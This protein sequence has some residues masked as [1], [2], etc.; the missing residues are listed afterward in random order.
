MRHPI[1]AESHDRLALT[2]KAIGAGLWDYDID[3]D[4]LQCSRRWYDILGLDPVEQPV[5][6]IEDFK[7][8]IHPD[9]VEIATAVD[10][11]AIERLLLTD[12]PYHVEFRIIRPDGQIRRLRSVASVVADEDNGHRRAVGCV[13]DVTDD[14][15]LTSAL[16]LPST[17]TEA[18][19]AQESASLLTNREREC[20]LWVSAGKTAWETS[21]IL[22]LSRRTI[23]FHLR[24]ATAKL[25]AANKVHAAA[26]AIR[27]GIL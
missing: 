17:A 13:T 7:R 22:G 20:L 21:K 15:S 18:D 6:S 9:D 19:I 25:K 12:E 8:H 24:N 5:L 23:E 11:A 14:D 1:A 4:T 27:S 10:F 3:A 2:I 26:T 16:P